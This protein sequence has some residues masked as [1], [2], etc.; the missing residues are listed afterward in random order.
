MYSDYEKCAVCGAAVRLL[1]HPGVP[2][3]VPD[4]PAGPEDG[5]VG[6]GDPTVDVREC[7]NPDCPSLRPGGPGA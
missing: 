2:D 4:G 3:E 5:V 7:T 6:G 1:P